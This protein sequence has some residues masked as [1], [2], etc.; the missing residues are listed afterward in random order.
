MV[1]ER[2][3]RWCSSGAGL[4]SK[5]IVLVGRVLFAVTVIWL[6]ALAL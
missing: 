2:V 1:I 5:K 6:V 3:A 4:N